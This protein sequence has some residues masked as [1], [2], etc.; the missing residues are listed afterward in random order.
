MATRSAVFST[1]AARPGRIARQPRD[2]LVGSVTEFADMEIV[3]RGKIVRT[4]ADRGSPDRDRQIERMRRRQ[5]C[6]LL[7]LDVHAADE[8]GF[9]HWKSSGLAGRMSRR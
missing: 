4:S 5:I 7:A 3:E 1:T 8:D 6:Y 9:R 2:Q